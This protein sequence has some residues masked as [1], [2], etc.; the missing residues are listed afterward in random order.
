L[1]NYVATCGVKEVSTNEEMCE[2][3]KFLNSVLETPVGKY[4][5]GYLTA[6]KLISDN[7]MEFKKQVYKI[8]FEFYTREVMNDSSGFEHVFLGE[9]KNN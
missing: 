3:R 1:D 7:Y 8:W 9:I 5:H 4:L 2:N 6:K